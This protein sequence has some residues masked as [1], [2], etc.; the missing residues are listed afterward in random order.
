MQFV[1]DGPD[2]PQSLL[3]AHEEG[4]VVFFCG[5]GISYPAMPT[6]QGLVDAIYENLGEHPSSMETAAYKRDQFDATLDLLERRIPG[7]RLA[8]RR[9]LEQ[10]LKPQ[11]RL[12]KGATDT[13][14]A[15]LQLGRSRDG[16]L[17]L[18]TTNFDR[19]FD[20]A[21]KRTKQTCV[22]Y[23]AP[24]LPIPKASRWDGVVY[25]HG[26]L[27][28]RRDDNALHRLVVTSGD[29]GLA[30]LTERWAARFVTELFRNYVVCFIG[31]S[32]N[33][34]VLRYMMDALAADRMLGERTPQAYA[35]GDCETGEEKNKTTEWTA[36]GVS[37]ILY[38]RPPGVHDHSALHKTLKAWA[39]TYRDGVSGQERIVVEHAMA[40]PAA[41]SSEDDYVGRM[42]WA[43]SHDSGIPAARFA[44]LDPVPSL[45]WLEALSERRCRY[46]DLSRFGVPP[47]S[48][49]DTKLSFSFTRRPAPYGLAPW[50]TI[51]SAT[52]QSVQ[53]DKVMFH[54]AR[55][56]TRHLNDPELVL[57]LA[58][59]GGQLHSHL[60]TL[61][62]REL[63]RIHQ[64]ERHSNTVELDRIRDA[65]PNAIP[66]PLMR[67]LWRLMLSGR[68]RS[69]NS[70]RDLYRFRD[71]VLRDGMTA[72]A[73]WELR[74]IL[75]PMIA[76]RERIPWNFS[77]VPVDLP[78]R[79]DQLV[80]WDLVLASSDARGCL[81][82]L[83]DPDWRRALPALLDEFETLL[84]D[85]LD[86]LLEIQ[87]IDAHNDDSHWALPS[88]VE[89]EQNQGFVEW[90]T[91][92]ELVREAWLAAHA[93]E[94]RQAR[95]VAHRWFEIPYPTF[96]RLAIF[97]AS[98]DDGIAPED[99]VAWLVA[100]SARWLWSLE[101][102]REAI[103]LIVL[104][105]S[106]LAGSSLVRLESAIL[107]G[108]PRHLY[109]ASIDEDSWNSLND[110]WVWLRLAKLKLSGAT[111]SDAGNARYARL[112][113]LNPRWKIAENQSD[114]FS[115]WMG[116]SGESEDDGSD[117]VDRAPR[118]R[119]ELV[120]WLQRSPSA[121]APFHDDAWRDVCRTRFFQSVLALCD[122]SR[123]GLWPISRWIEA[124][125]AW[126][127]ED[128]VSRSWRYA[129]PLVQS[130]PDDVFRD[131]V[132]ALT[133][134][135]ETA[136]KKTDASEES[137]LSL[138]ARV[139]G[140]AQVVGSF[141][142]PGNSMDRPVAEAINHPVGHVAQTVLNLWFRRKPKDDDQLPTDIR[143]LLTQICD[144]RLTHF[145]PGRVI[146]ASQ[147]VA[148]FRVDREWT[149]ANLLPFFDWNLHPS[150][151]KFAWEGFL[152][153]PRL[154][155]PLLVALKS[156]FLETPT[157]YAELGSH[158]RQFATLLTYAALELVEGFTTDD[159]RISFGTLPQEGLLEVAQS[160][161]R[162]QE[163][164]GG[165]R[166]EYWRNRVEP[167]WRRVWPKSLDVS[168]D[169]L[170]ESLSL[171]S[172][173]TGSEFP[174]A[175]DAIVHWMHPIEQSQYVV[176][177]LFKSGLC[178][179]FPRE[180][181]RLLNALILS[182]VVAPQNVA[183]CLR[184][185]V[186]ADPNLDGDV[187]LRRIRDLTRE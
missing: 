81:M 61:V 150:E 124:L 77:T 87:H 129:S 116:A 126:S 99:W 11:R 28:A 138:C 43:L 184:A 125:H 60:A 44:D 19:L 180:C 155:R 158:R 83:D 102:Q 170:V 118:K 186:A 153:S 146:V 143:A 53:W 163:A 40:R 39:E 57:W 68:V 131:V 54:L 21:A 22:G 121:A 154:Y 160:L 30:Y 82:D 15:L 113:S 32:I 4:R 63:D 76:I 45:E 173:A 8:M 134:W 72:T 183:Q 120:V 55:W 6:F 176:T 159:W 58:R 139:L 10:R 67:V 51:A 14:A 12:H 156:P 9:A 86:L 33:D 96:K 90:A 35:L 103:R 84:R 38:G 65:S 104:R 171:L 73:R 178:S 42:L 137:M 175:L 111:L 98:Q 74:A 161:A 1:A 64:L 152:R 168:T 165:Q 18:V 17:R 95:K 177:R 92:I 46:T 151:A 149:V 105:G 136:S 128:V 50:M 16:T 31:Y 5:A 164:A 123:S 29:F 36:K 20:K 114:E 85:A 157:H 47:G 80:D 7:Q 88:I 56:L 181:L 162:A 140:L 37:P 187:R 172:I 106:T 135:I 107:A 130:M 109:A 167:F 93:E 144:H 100:D 182:P 71:R 117:S 97:A 174:A 3:E 52:S 59:Q 112:S 13:H 133:S 49:N 48:V 101:T 148:L 110:R 115:S 142:E 34:P 185:I 70:N 27:P 62:E 127:E 24:M 79:L 26:L 91:L 147:L 166:E 66:S 169:N 2:I 89:H 145:R 122:L 141:G 108:P 179:Q 23:A 69:N 119:A 41:S 132:R 78:T 25:L 94:P 75:A